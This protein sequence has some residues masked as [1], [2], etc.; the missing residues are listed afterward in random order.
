MAAQWGIAA[1]PLRRAL[2]DLEEKGLLER[3]QG[4][5]NYIRARNLR[6]HFYSRFRIELLAGGGFPLAQTLSIDVLSEPADLPDFGVSACASRIRRLRFL[7]SQ[8]QGPGELCADA[9]LGTLRAKLPP[10]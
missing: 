2:E 1:G 7:D 6:W 10:R 5:G 3:V 8:R 9:R 4:S